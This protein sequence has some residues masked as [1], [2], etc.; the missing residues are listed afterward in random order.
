MK[1]NIYFF[2]VVISSLTVWIHLYVIDCE[3]YS[4]QVEQFN[5]KAFHNLLVNVISINFKQE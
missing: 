1:R 4:I 5:L 2:F 3:N